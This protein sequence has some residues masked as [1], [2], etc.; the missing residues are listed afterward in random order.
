MTPDVAIV[1]IDNEICKLTTMCTGIAVPADDVVQAQLIE[2]VP[3]R[4]RRWRIEAYRPRRRA[5][6]ICVS[7]YSP[8]GG[9]SSQYSMNVQRDVAIDHR[10]HGVPV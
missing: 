4:R 7:R 2:V 9:A 8:R 10:L 3:R 6:T 5:W 1:D